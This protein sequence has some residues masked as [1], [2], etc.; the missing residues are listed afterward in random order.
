MIS[1]ESGD[2]RG[3][4]TIWLNPKEVTECWCGKTLSKYG[5]V[6]NDVWLEKECER[7]N[8]G[9]HKCKIV[10]MDDK[11]ALFYIDGYFDRFGLWS[12]L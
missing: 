9:K 12:N 10:E 4:I 3:R 2:Y 5:R 8:S 1:K 11:K 7:I 6:S